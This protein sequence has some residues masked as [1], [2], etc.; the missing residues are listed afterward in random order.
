MTSAWLG[1]NALSVW[2]TD[3]AGLTSDTLVIPVPGIRVLPTL[4]YPLVTTTVPGENDGVLVDEPRR[5]IYLLQAFPDAVVTLDA[6]TLAV[7]STLPLPSPALAFD[8]TPGG[9]SLLLTMASERALGIVDLQ[10]ATPHLGLVPMTTLDSAAGQYPEEIAVTGN[11]KA[12][13]RLGA[14]VSTQARL[15]E[16]DLAS[17]GERIRTDAGESGI[18]RYAHLG[19]AG[20]RTALVLTVGDDHLQ[21]YEAASDAFGPLRDMRS[22]HPPAVDRTGSLVLVGSDL[23]DA[24]LDFLRE[25]EPATVLPYAL[26]PAADYAYRADGR[27]LQRARLTDGR[28]VDR[29]AFPFPVNRITL[30]PDGKLVVTIEQPSN[31]STVVRTVT[32]P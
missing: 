2:A 22:P 30:A 32:L 7:R 15:V 6:A 25:L 21:H 13:I 19:T 14:F 26:A 1:D 24:A 27:G 29:I 12:F 5:A 4:T 16:F 17:R 28:A 20:D 18:V 9:D 11:H 31:A 23:Y 10:V 8:Q 3:D